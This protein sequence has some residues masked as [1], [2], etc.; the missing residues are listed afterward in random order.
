MSVDVVPLNGAV[1]SAVQLGVADAI[2]DVVETGTTLKQAGLET[3][4]P[5]MLESEAVLIQG[6]NDAAG[7]D[8]LLRRV[9]GVLVARR[10]VMLDYDLPADLVDA[11]TE[12]ATGMQSPTIS[13]LQRE[14]W[15]AVRVMLPRGDVN[16]IMDDLYALG[17]RALLVTAIDNARL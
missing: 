1:E 10:Y 5:V 7:V 11:A 14:G 13:P 8:R 3:F 16:R 4:G 12:I 15:V 17:A 2:A 6:P 9:R